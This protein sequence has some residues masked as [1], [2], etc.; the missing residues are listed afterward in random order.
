VGGKWA[1]ASYRREWLCPYVYDITVRPAA[2]KTSPGET[3]TGTAPAPDDMPALIAGAGGNPHDGGCIMQAV[4]WLASGG[5]EWTD[6][7]ACAHPVVRKVAI[8]VNDS[9]GAAAYAGRGVAAGGR[10]VAPGDAA[11]IA[12]L[13]E[14]IDE[15]DRIAGRTAP[16]PV[17]A[18]LWDLL[19]A[20]MAG[21]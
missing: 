9:V 6:A 13:R 17:T 8:W 2:V 4:S 11:K 19:R 12:F 10:G 20:E 14:L 1:H 18:V 7:P 16:E 15:H 5:E 3:M 21:A